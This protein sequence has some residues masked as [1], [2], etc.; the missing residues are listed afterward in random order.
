MSDLLKKIADKELFVTVCGKSG[1]NLHSGQLARELI[2][3][4]QKGELYQRQVNE[5]A[6]EMRKYHGAG[7]TCDDDSCQD[8]MY[9]KAFRAEVF[10]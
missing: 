4:A 2:N 1:K 7:W 8:H 9:C 3:L 5:C 6:G 10:E